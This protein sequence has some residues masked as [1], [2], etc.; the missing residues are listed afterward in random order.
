M[1]SFSLSTGISMDHLQDDLQQVL[2]TR[3]PLAA[4]KEEL[5]RMSAFLDLTS[6]EGNDNKEKI[7]QLCSKARALS[8]HFLPFPA[9][10]CIYSPFIGTAREFL[11]GTPVKVATVAAA[12]PHGQQPLKVKLEEIR[13]AVKEG[14]DEID[15]V[16]SRGTFLEKD[17]STV[18]RELDA[19][20]EATH[21]KT[22]KV[23]LE[24]GELQTPENIAKASEL[25]IETGADFIKTSTGKVTPAATEASV[26]IMLRIIREH[27]RKT[28]KKVGI[29]PA[30][31]IADA[32]KALNYY[33]LV[34]EVLGESWLH[35][36]YFRLGA[37]RLADQLIALA[38][39]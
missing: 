29:K 2:S 18:Y 6:L 37:S 36:D 20:R 35:P 30:G 31:G 13:Y 19:M 9:A 33:W 7:A 23:I 14:A 3:P 38:A 22:L 1:L 8:S 21:G 11:A 10:V 17:Y 16:I 39:L 12:F 25:A 15:I 28:G 26:F 5:K 32:E 27:F 4:M 34:R 24:T